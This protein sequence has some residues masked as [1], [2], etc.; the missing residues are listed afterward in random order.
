[1]FGGDG[2]WIGLCGRSGDLCLVVMGR[3]LGCVWEEWRDMFGCDGDRIG[4]QIF[5]LMVES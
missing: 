1:M 3:G 2:V 4:F 5:P